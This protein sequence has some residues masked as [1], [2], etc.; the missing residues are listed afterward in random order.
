MFFGCAWHPQESGLFSSWITRDKRLSQHILNR[1]FSTSSLRSCSSNSLS[2]L[3]TVILTTF[4]SC[5]SAF[6]VLHCMKEDVLQA[7]KKVPT[8]GNIQS[9]EPECSVLY[10]QA[11]LCKKLQRPGRRQSCS[12]RSLDNQV[13]GLNTLRN[14]AAN[15]RITFIDVFVQ[16]VQEFQRTNHRW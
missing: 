16:R 15:H 2:L 14:P 5:F 6:Q 4:Q 13:S 9:Q 12:F 3:R 10:R 1:R 7:C 11:W 8:S